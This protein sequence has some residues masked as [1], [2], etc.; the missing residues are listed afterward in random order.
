VL[1]TL[2]AVLL[3][4]SALVFAGTALAAPPGIE[5]VATLPLP[6][7]KGRIDHFAFDPRGGRIFV[8]ALGNDTVEILDP[9]GGNRRTVSGLGEPQGLLYLPDASRLV[10][11]NGAAGRVDIVDGRSL[12]TVQRIPRIDDAD[13]VRWWPGERAVLV[14][15]GRGGLRVLDGDTW[16]SRGDIR[17]PGHPESF[18]LDPVTRRA[19][20]NVPS[21]HAVLVVDLASRRAV[22]RWETPYAS[23]NFPMALDVQG[24]RLYVAART[25]PVLLVYDVDAGNVLARIPIGGDADDLYFDAERKRVYAICG[26]GRLDVIRQ[27]PG[28]RYVIEESLATAAG[29]RTGLF[30]PSE[31]KLYV[32]APARGEKAARILVYAIR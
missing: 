16:Q 17:L 19:Y 28:N 23:A 13:N 1:T 6:G 12:E 11:A 30:I 24:R 3:A 8:A 20:V 26:E 22:G 31:G 15:Y 7:V 2:R 14:G 29:A 9:H 25:P 18:Q 21:A 27:E 10:I 5:L 32:A 4:C